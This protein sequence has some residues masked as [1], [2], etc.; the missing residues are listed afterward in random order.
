MKY[1]H[2]CD[3]AFILS[4]VTYL[5]MIYLDLPHTI[6][7]LH[8]ICYCILCTQQQEIAGLSIHDDDTDVLQREYEAILKDHFNSSQLEEQ[9]RQSANDSGNGDLDKSTSI[10]WQTFLKEKDALFAPEPGSGLPGAGEKFLV[11]EP[12]FERQMMTSFVSHERSE[13]AGTRKLEVRF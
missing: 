7:T 13:G 1:F 2:R 10:K 5:G 6:V 4:H 12:G 3:S 9:L 11:R 8:L